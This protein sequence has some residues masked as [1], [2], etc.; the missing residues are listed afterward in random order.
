MIRRL[1]VRLSVLLLL[2]ALS[3][4]SAL[5]QAVAM[6]PTPPSRAQVLALLTA[7]G[8]RQNVENSLHKAQLNIRTSA[9]N[10]LKKKRPDAT[11][12]DLKKL[13]AVF[14][15]TPLFGFED[16]SEI[17][18]DVYQKNLS[19]ADVQAG[20]DFYNSEAGQRL[21]GKLPTIIREANDSS[22]ELVQKKLSNY[23]DSLQRKL[24]AFEVE[25]EKQHPADKSAPGAENKSK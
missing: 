9:H 10:A 2:A 17:L 5:A 25:F 6:D 23:A 14:D 16:I 22:Q 19:A 13:D 1:G 12:A 11:E 15:T 24:E 4:G 18:I 3:S 8:I 21:V 7:M 20:I